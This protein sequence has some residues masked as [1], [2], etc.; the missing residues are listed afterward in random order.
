M[1]GT[2]GQT[3]SIR[4]IAEVMQGL[5]VITRRV[6]HE[7]LPPEPYHNLKMRSQKTFK[8]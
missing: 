8:K 5:D 2:R 1:R 7:G 4:R 6:Y 3:I